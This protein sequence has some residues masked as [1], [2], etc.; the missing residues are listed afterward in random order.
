MAPDLYLAFV[1]ATAIL[2]VIPGPVVTF[3]VATSLAQGSRRALTVVAGSCLA[4]VAHMLV[5]GFGMTSALALLA[6]WFEWLRWLGV[7]YLIYLGIQAWRERPEA[8]DEGAKAAVPTRR[9]FWQGFL[10]NV[11]NPKSL[12]FYAAFFPQFIDPAAAAG[13]QL[14]LICV[15]FFAIATIFDT[16][17][18]LAAGRVRQHL[19]SPRGARIRA[20]VSGSLLI[21]AGVGLALARRGS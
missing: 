14:L 10:V 18:A 2:I 9:L 19:L 4:I 12:V 1:A 17:Y 21:G 7:A 5:I 8:V 3:V 6:Q 11:T 13:P 16:S 20:R 15:T